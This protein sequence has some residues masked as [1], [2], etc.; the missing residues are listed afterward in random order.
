M[1]SIIH[2]HHKAS[3]RIDIIIIPSLSFVS[4]S[5]TR[6]LIIF[7]TGYNNVI[8]INI[9]NEFPTADQKPNFEKYIFKKKMKMKN[10]LKVFLKII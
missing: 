5:V 4:F 6:F 8:I 3:L 7:E 1:K 2:E 10:K 9:E